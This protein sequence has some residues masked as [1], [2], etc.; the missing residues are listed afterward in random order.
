M[1]C[2]MRTNQY[3]NCAQ[4]EE[5]KCAWWDNEKSQCCIKTLALKQP[6]AVQKIEIEKD[7]GKDI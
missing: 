2:P 1:R 4:C 7:W 3:G 5:E 6:K